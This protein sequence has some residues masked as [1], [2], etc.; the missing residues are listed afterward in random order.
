MPAK[1]TAKPAKDKPP[2]PS[3]SEVIDKMEAEHLNITPPEKS[4]EDPQATPKR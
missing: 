3:V 1:K 4:A 2:M